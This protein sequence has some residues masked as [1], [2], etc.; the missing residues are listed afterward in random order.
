[1]VKEEE[2]EKEITEEKIYKKK[3]NMVKETGQKR[4]ITKK[5][6]RFLL[7]SLGLRGIR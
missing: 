6:R 4:T 2:E 5:E 1:V 3:D 7:K